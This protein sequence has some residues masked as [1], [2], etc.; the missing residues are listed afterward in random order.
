MSENSE[1]VL[2]ELDH[3]YE[4]AL[5]TVG[6]W[7]PDTSGV[8]FLRACHQLCPAAK[9]AAQYLR[10]CHHT[11]PAAILF[12]LICAD[13][14]ADWLA[15][16][17]ERDPQGSLLTG[18]DLARWPLDRPPLPQ[19]TSTLGVFAAGAVRHGSVERVAS[20]VG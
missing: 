9:A 4:V 16:A 11:Y 6:Q 10:R 15:D 19:E 3:D 5:A 13:P 12:L 1:T 7:L 2:A 18:S 20:A 8:D 14:H 17:V